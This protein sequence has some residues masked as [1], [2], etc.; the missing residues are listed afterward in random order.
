MHNK[1]ETIYACMDLGSNMFRMI[2]GSN[3]NGTWKIIRSFSWAIGIGNHDGYINTI[4][5]KRIFAGVEKAKNILSEYD[6]VKILCVAT[7]AMRSA[8][9]ADDIIRILMDKYG[10]VCRIIDPGIEIMLSGLGCKDVFLD[11]LSLFIDMGGGSTEIGLFRKTQHTFYV[12]S[13]ISIPYGLFYCSKII[14]KK[15]YTLPQHVVRMIQHFM[16]GVNNKNLPLIICK[17]GIVSFVSIYLSRKESMPKSNLNGKIMDKH[18]L[19]KIVDD[20]LHMP[21]VDL[22]KYK[23]TNRIASISS[24]RG[25]LIFTKQIISLLPVEF[26]IIGNGGVKEGMLYT[27]L[28]S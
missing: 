5:V 7:A 21:D 14:Y 10:I 23:I 24:L 15:H 11:G 4:A 20:I 6:N 9:N 2:L 26:V 25:S 18:T 13:W 1:N 12:V 17:S 22:I 16:K 28:N 19:Y 8:Q 27:I 3:D